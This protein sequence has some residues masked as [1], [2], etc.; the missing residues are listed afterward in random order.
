MKFIKSLKK[1][2]KESKRSSLVVYAVLRALVIFCM[3][4]Q[5]IRGNFDNA[6]LCL[7]SLILLF[8]PFFIQRGLKI[9]LPNTLEIIIL[10]FIFS[11]EILGEIRNFYGIFPFWDTMLHT[12]NGFL[13]AAI[14]F[15][16]VNLLN[17]N[18]K[19]I[20]LSPLYLCLVAFCFSMTIGVVWEFFE[21][22]VDQVLKQDMQKDRV[23]E[24]ISSVT[25]DEKHDNNAIVID[26]IDHTIL[27]DKDGNELMTIE[28]GYLDI[29]IK[30]T[31][32]DLIVNFIGAVVFSLLGYFY[33][34]SNGEKSF[35]NHFVPQKGLRKEGEINKK[36]KVKNKNQKNKKSI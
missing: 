32:K 14:G 22:G 13:C 19:K 9:T 11:A 36:P 26:N 29:G 33:I 17:K 5:I 2:Y 23:T 34:I 1:T 4:M 25:F 35:I 16:L 7:L 31:M 18:S 20:S 3:V 27:Y 10:L 30:D 12:L 24:V 21:F 8:L 6:M 15:S 28:N